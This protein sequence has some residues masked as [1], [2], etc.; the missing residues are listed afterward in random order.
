MDEGVH[1]IWLVLVEKIHLDVV[2]LAD[3]VAV[4]NLVSGVVVCGDER[5]ETVQ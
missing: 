5:V 1:V 4:Q 2:P 3:A